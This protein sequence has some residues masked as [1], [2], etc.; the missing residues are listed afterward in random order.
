MALKA[1]ATIPKS[2]SP[3]L[4]AR[5]IKKSTCIKILHSF[6]MNRRDLEKSL[7]AGLANLVKRSKVSFSFV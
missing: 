5:N 1:R 4:K 7:Q 3:A 6:N 2:L